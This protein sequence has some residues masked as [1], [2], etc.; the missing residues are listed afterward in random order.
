MSG[1]ELSTRAKKLLERIKAGHFYPAYHPATPKAMEELIA[2]GLVK[3]GGRASVYVAA[4]VPVGYIMG[5][6]MMPPD[7]GGQRFASRLYR[8]PY[9]VIPKLALESMPLDW[10]RR[11]EALLQE[12][13]ATGLV[14]PGYLVFREDSPH[15]LVTREDPDN[16]Y[17]DIEKVE[18]Y[19]ADPWANYRRGDIG[20]LCPTFKPEGVPL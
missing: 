6:D 13:D 4:Y 8:S 15:T 10:Q 14:T 1:A 9:L 11:F 5:K 2:A 20:E 19:L 3:R 17:S 16:P 7:D 12:C 18:P